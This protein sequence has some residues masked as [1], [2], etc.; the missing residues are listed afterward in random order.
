MSGDAD[1]LLLVFG[2]FPSRFLGFT[3]RR[4]LLHGNHVAGDGIHIH[5]R[6][7]LGVRRGDVKR[8]DQLAFFLFQFAFFDRAVG[9]F[10]QRDFLGVGPADLG[11]GHEFGLFGLF[12]VMFFTFG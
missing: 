4:F 6:D 3:F 8:P 10:C 12:V 1:G 9:R 5:F 2:L 7:V 11:L